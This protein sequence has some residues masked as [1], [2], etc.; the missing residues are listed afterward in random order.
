MPGRKHPRPRKFSLTHKWKHFRVCQIPSDLKMVLGR[1]QQRGPHS[2]TVHNEGLLQHV[3]DSWG[4]T[5]GLKKYLW[6]FFFKPS[7]S[8]RPSFLWAKVGQSRDGEILVWP[9]RPGSKKRPSDRN[10]NIYQ[11]FLLPPRPLKPQLS[12]CVFTERHGI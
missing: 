6:R 1:A 10:R 11:E 2:V 3:S 5:Q 12:C 9:F 7:R 4:D 8:M